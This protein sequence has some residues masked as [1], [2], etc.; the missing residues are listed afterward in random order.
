VLAIDRNHAAAWTKFGD[1]RVEQNDL[2]AA[3][4]AYQR[5]LALEPD[6]MDAANNLGKIR[7][8]PDN[9]G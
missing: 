6:D 3:V 5:A 4:E 9:D 8:M 7:E 2:A 1:V